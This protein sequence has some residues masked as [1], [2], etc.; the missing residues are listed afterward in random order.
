MSCFTLGW[1]AASLNCSVLC[2]IDN[3]SSHMF[4]LYNNTMM[5]FLR[6]FLDILSSALTAF[7]RKFEAA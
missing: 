4:S 6:I 7:K 1:K 5:H 2:F 3:T